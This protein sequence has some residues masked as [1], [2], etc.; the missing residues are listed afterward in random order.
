[1]IKILAKRK[2]GSKVLIRSHDYSDK[3]RNLM[4]SR[5]RSG[6]IVDYEVIA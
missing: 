3:F 4:N 6:E 1:M 5:L 2:D